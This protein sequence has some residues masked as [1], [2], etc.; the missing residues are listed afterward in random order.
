MDSRTLQV[1]PQQ[2]DGLVALLKAHGLVLDPEAAA[3]EVKTGGWDVSWTQVPGQV[4]S[5]ITINLVKHPWLEAGAF[6][7]KIE[8]VLKPS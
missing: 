2:L 5:E 6:W 8:N 4:T 7:A 3:G 1:T